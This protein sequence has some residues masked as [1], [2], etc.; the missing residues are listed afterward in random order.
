MLILK[1]IGVVALTGGGLAA[2]VLV[3]P[4]MAVDSVDAIALIAALALGCLVPA[5]LLAWSLYRRPAAED[6]RA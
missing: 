4:W 3:D 6:A 5:G 1:W 2:P